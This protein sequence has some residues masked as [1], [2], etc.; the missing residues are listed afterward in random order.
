LHL[1]AKP[2]DNV[3]TVPRAQREAIT[4]KT[5]HLLTR[6]SSVP[7]SPGAELRRLHLHI[8]LSTVRYISGI[9]PGI[10][11]LLCVHNT[12]IHQRYKYPYDHSRC[13]T[14]RIWLKLLNIP[15]WEALG[16]G[17]ATSG[18][19]KTFQKRRVSSAAADATVQPSGL[20]SSTA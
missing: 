15:V 17:F 13:S 2:R 9:Y 16:A 4:T 18:V 11:S 3:P 14:H 5:Q 1:G 12:A 10:F 20:C 19:P 8:F 6:F 7:T